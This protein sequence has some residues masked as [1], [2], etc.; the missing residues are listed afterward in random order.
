MAWLASSLAMAVSAPS[1]DKFENA[2]APG[3]LDALH[4]PTRWIDGGTPGYAGKEDTQALDTIAEVLQ[5]RGT[6]DCSLTP[7]LS[8]VQ[9]PRSLMASLLATRAKR[10][11]LS[12][13]SPQVASKF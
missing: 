8:Q 2:A 10:V 7:C 1:P 11:L 12:W 3:L 6:Q 9:E 13:T 4:P 5:F